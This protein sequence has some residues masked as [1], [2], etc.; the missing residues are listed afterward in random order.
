MINKFE[1]NNKVTNN[2]K[3]V[4]LCFL[5]PPL[6]LLISFFI[7]FFFSKAPN[8]IEEYAACQKDL[9]HFLNSEMS[10][11][12]NFQFNITQLGDALIFFPFLIIF[13]YYAPKLWQALLTSSIFSLLI[14]ATFKTVFAVPRPAAIYDNNSLVIIGKRTIGLTSLPSGH[15]ITAFMIITIL[16]YAFM[17]KKISHKIAWSVLLFTFGFMIAFSRV[18]IAAHYPFDVIIG[19]AIGYFVA[20]IGIKVN[21]NVNW[22]EW[23]KNKKV[24]PFFILILLIGAF[25]IIKK[26]VALN[27]P[28]FY[29]SLLSLVITFFIITNAYVKRN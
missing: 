2:F 9:F 25:L 14:S 29:L 15:S 28:I 23:I 7:Y 26:I 5:I 12:P 1:L 11:Y 8:F 22:L 13:L 17:P 3:I 4:K 10:K 27:L 21:N 18:G 24:D 6:L 19:C 20:I 16:L